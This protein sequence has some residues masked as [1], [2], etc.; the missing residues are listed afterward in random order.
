MLEA[1]RRHS[2]SWLIWVTLGIIIIVFI[3]FFGP[4]AGGFDRNSNGW[5]V[6]T[7]GGNTV[8]IAELDRT[9][10]RT[11]RRFLTGPTDEEFYAAKRRVAMDLGFV[12]YLAVQARSTGLAIPE[13]EVACYIVNWNPD[14]RD[15]RGNAICADFPADYPTR[16]QNIDAVFYT[17]EDGRMSASYS[18]DV[19]GRF[20]LSVR[21]FEEWKRRELLAFKYLDTLAASVAVSPTQVEQTWRRRNE[22]V[23]IE[24]VRL[25]PAGI[26]ADLP[27]EGEAA[28]WASSHGA[29]IQA[30]YDENVANYSLARRVHLRR[31]YITKPSGDPAA[32]SAAEERFTTLLA[33]A[34]ADPAGFEELARAETGLDAERESGGD[35]G[36]RTEDTLSVDIWEATSGVEVGSVVGVTQSYSWNI[37]KLEAVEEAR[38][39]PIDEVRNDIAAIL[40]QQERIEEERGRL[41][42]RAERVLELAAAGET[43]EAA[44]A[45]EAGERA[46]RIHRRRLEDLGSGEEEPAR[47][48]PQPLAVSETGPFARETPAPDL[49]ALGADFA[50]F[51]ISAPPADQVPT[52][53]RSRD[54]MRAAFALSDDAPLHSELIRVDEQDYII[55]MIERVVP[56]EAPEGELA[57]IR[58]ELQRSIADTLVDSRGARV[59]LTLHLDQP[60]APVVQQLLDDALASGDIRL[61]EKLFRVDPADSDEE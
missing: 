34:Q 46:D 16:Y 59:R 7:K 14:Y 37:V 2:R 25:D 1:L 20:G 45:T 17:E 44:A 52:I 12:E 56:D 11:V 10:D 61:R 32:L 22:T 55:R 6:R 21:A 23:N 58:A 54:L 8:N 4:Q 5:A 40:L 57:S 3:F 35:M 51:Q 50:G 48:A 18:T 33:R 31:L 49:S 60:Y 15:K 53:G 38:Q 41:V 29:E 30:Y 19:R 43:L 24:Y 27:E 39:Q 47:P 9:Y 42:R 28:T 13:D 36:F 26:S